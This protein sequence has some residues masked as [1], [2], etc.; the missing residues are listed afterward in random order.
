MKDTLK[1]ISNSNSIRYWLPILLW[2]WFIYYL[3]DQPSLKSSFDPL[4]D[5]LLRKIF[6]MIEFGILAFLMSRTLGFYKV[7]GWK[8]WFLVLTVS[9]IYAVYDEVHQSF[10][11]GRYGTIRDM[12]VDFNGAF[13]GVVV[14]HLYKLEGKKKRKHQ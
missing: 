5:M 3:S 10:V 7:N 4:W 13:L 11:Q 2:V 9:F 1:D 8:F 6:H 12:L 14:W